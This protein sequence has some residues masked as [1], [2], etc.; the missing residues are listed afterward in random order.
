MFGWFLFLGLT[1]TDIKFL[2]EHC[3]LVDKV[4]VGCLLLCFQIC[5]LLSTVYHT[6][7]CRSAKAYNIFL[8]YDMFGIALSLLAIFISGIYYAFW[9]Q[10]VRIFIFRSDW[11]FE[12]T[13][14]KMF[15]TL[16]NFYIISV[17]IIFIIAMVLQL[18]QLAVKDNIKMMALLGW[19]VYGVVPTCHWYFE[20][21]GSENKMVQVWN[22]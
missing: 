19:A 22:L 16:R 5:F 12:I 13:V 14:I 3:S 11:I 6:F 1:Y 21:G 8:S 18:P 15:Q 10:S 20:M 2:S 9:C 7:S 17:G 4:I